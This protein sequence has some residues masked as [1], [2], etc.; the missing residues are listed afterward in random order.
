MI[1]ATKH[2]WHLIAGENRARVYRPQGWISPVVLVDGRM[3]GTWSRESKGSRLKVE[4]QPFGPLPEWVIA[5][6][7]TEA[8]SLAEFFGCTDLELTW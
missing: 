8:Q 6:I 3:K 1:A 4:V 2:A 5:S 7:R